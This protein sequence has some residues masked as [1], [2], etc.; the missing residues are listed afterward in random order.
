M[1]EGREGPGAVEDHQ[2][3]SVQADEVGPA[4]RN[5]QVERIGGVNR[6]TVLADHRLVTRRQYAFFRFQVLT[7]RASSAMSAGMWSHS[8]RAEPARLS[9]M[10]TPRFFDPSTGPGV[11]HPR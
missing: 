5:R 4:G 6:V 7:K 10:L 3:R 11:T 9:V 8:A 1:L 2:R